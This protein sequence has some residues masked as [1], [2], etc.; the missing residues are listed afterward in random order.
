M[1]ANLIKNA[2]EASPEGADVSVRPE[3]KDGKVVVRIHNKGAVPEAIRDSFFQKY[4]SLG[5]ASGTGLGTYSARLMARVQDGDVAMQTSDEHGTTLIVTL[6]TAPD[7]AMPATTRHGADRL[8]VE[9]SLIASLPPTRVLLVDD[10][11]YNLLIVRRFLPSPPF[12]VGTA[13]NGR[14]A[15]AS[16]QVNW[17]DIVFMDL[18]MPVMGGMQAAQAMRALE[19]A[20]GK[21]GP[22][23]IIALSSHDDAET[24]AEALAAG[25]DRYLTKPVTRGAIEEMLMLFVAHEEPVAPIRT[26]APGTAHA[27]GRDDPVIVDP[28]VQAMLASF[29]ESRRSLVGAMESAMS[30]GDR[31]E[32]RRIAHQLSGS[33]SLYGFAWASAQARWIE[34]NAAHADAIR[35]HAI[36]REL[37]AHLDTV[38][39]RTAHGAIIETAGQPAR[40]DEA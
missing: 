35:L 6:H 3:A 37:Q 2:V 5:K 31:E 10:D 24:R 29:I 26:A 20:R 40:G 18:D 23:H 25:F 38:R 11:E 30:T 19:R 16:M 34:T 14:V 36:A 12:D 1:L 15:L 7:G 4:A 13:V 32:V 17:P 8:G 9:P 21:G 27:P 22:C 28:D 39:L 33:F